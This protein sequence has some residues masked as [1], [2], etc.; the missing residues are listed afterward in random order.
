MALQQQD[1]HPSVVSENFSKA[2][3]ELRQHIH[4]VQLPAGESIFHQSTP[5][6]EVHILYEGSVKLEHLFFSGKRFLINVVYPISLVNYC[7]L[8]EEKVYQVSAK[9]IKSSVIGFAPLKMYLEWLAEHPDLQVYQLI[10]FA[11]LMVW[12]HQRLAQVAYS[13]VRDQL[14]LSLYD[15]GKTQCGCCSG[16][17]QNIEID[18]NE[19]ELAEMVGSTR[20]TVVRELARIKQ[21][22]LL[23]VKGRAIIV[24]DLEQLKQVLVQN[25]LL[26]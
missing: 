15:L 1:C 12:T 25:N 2:L 6:S 20:E 24:K 21:E 5:I 23:F 13:N 19:Q 16:D 11:R 18:L 7:A 26:A 10:Q 4:V 9:T 8:G 3:N 22:G 14:L 17:Y